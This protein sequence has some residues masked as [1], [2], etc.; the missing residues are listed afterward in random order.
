MN[1]KYMHLR[2]LVKKIIANS[3]VAELILFKLMNKW[4]QVGMIHGSYMSMFACIFFW[5]SRFFSDVFGL[6]ESKNAIK[7]MFVNNNK[8]F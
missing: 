2:P 8:F 5:S 6:T 1:N 7:N 4:T 3:K